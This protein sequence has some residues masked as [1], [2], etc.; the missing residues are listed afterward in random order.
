MSEFLA[1]NPPTEEGLSLDH[2]PRCL[3]ANLD[4]GFDIDTAGLTSAIHVQLIKVSKT[5]N[6]LQRNTY[7]L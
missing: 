3:V 1:S 7:L 4:R 6:R 2:L 5:V